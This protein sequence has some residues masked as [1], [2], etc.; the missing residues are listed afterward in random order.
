[1][2]IFGIERLLP[3]RFGPFVCV[4]RG[5]VFAGEASQLQKNEARTKKVHEPP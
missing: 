1:M 5:N 4:H 2:I 3:H